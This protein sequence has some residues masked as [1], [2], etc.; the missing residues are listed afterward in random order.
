MSCNGRN[1][2]PGWG[3]EPQPL[4]E[5]RHHGVLLWLGQ[6][7]ERGAGHASFDQHH[8]GVVEGGCGVQLNGP[9]GRPRCAAPRVR[10]RLRGPPGELEHRVASI[11]GARWRD[12]GGLPTRLKGRPDL[13]RP[14]A[15]E[16]GRRRPGATRPTPDVARRRP[17]VSPWRGYGDQGTGPAPPGQSGPLHLS[18]QSRSTLP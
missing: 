14:L 8:D 5:R 2:C 1:G 17:T 13:H 10:V 12:P 11:A 4:E 15:P 9:R 7:R 18:S 16:N 6:R 3:V